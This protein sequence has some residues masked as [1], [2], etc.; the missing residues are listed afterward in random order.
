MDCGV[1]ESSK[2][3]ECTTKWLNKNCVKVD[4]WANWRHFEEIK[5]IR[6]NTRVSNET[7]M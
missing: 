6:P 5:G 4:G 3:A 2:V 1:D 7:L